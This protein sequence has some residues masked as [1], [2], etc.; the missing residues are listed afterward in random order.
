MRVLRAA[1][2]MLTVAAIA[3]PAAG[4]ATLTVN[5]TF[6]ETNA[7]DGSCSLRE[8][9]LAVD[10]PGSASGDCA[11]AAFGA[12]T[13]VL[14]PGRY[15]LGSASAPHVSLQIA[16]TVTNLTIEGAGVKQTTIDAFGLGNRVF[17]VSPGASVTI[18]D[19]EVAGGQAPDGSAGSPGGVGGDGQNGGAILNQ[20]VLSLVDAM[21]DSSQAGNGGAGGGAGGA[22]S[23]PAS[24]GGA[25]GAGGEGG[26]IFNTGALTLTGATIARTSSGAGGSGGIGG[27]ESTTNPGG[28]GGAGGAGGNGA[29]LANEGG[30]VTITASTIRGNTGG[31]AGTGGTGGGSNNGGGS[32]GGTG[33]IGGAGSSG[34]GVWS[35]GGSLHIT[36]STIASN[37]TGDGGGGGIGG[38]GVDGGTGGHGAGGGNSGSGGG[39][40]VSGL[41]S[42]Q[43]VNVTVVGNKVGQPGPAGAGGAGGTTGAAGSAGTA[44]AGGGLAGVSAAVLAVENSLLALNG[45]SNCAPST[46]TDGGHNLSFGDAT[47]PPSFANGDPNLGPLQ[48]NGG[49]SWTVSLLTGSAAIDQIPAS[50]ADCPATDQRGVARPVGPKCDIGA[51]EAAGPRATTNAATAVGRTNATLNG[52]VTPNSGLASVHF[53]YGTT[54][55]Y[56]S[57]TSARLVTGV[58]PTA[59][60]ATVRG[61][62]AGVTYHFRLVATTSDGTVQGVDRTFTTTI[63]PKLTRPTLKAKRFKAGRGTTIS[64]SDS[65][66]ATT[67]FVVLRLIRHR[68][69]SRVARFSHRDKAGRNSVQYKAR[70]LKPGSYRLQSTPGLHGLKGSTVSVTFTI[71]R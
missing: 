58:T 19:L 13:I 5:S 53:I 6:D 68:K 64:Y 63:A 17:G 55:K 70:G 48:D 18:R 44:G 15:F 30:T 2:A 7:S 9:I 45:G 21:I 47:C 25:G 24:P 69:P 66:A 49:P 31:A 61:L 57:S 50:G 51:Y 59:V 39:V 41:P 46:V 33:G 65:K 56:G 37:T 3:A 1:S 43:L 38:I 29:G 16:S 11:A 14:K 60:T 8:A 67:N 52:S 22:P 71:T 23:D 26:G 32:T 20:G 36:N 34:G 54:T 4:A 35:T 10:S 62:R 12:N 40:A 42:P 28:S 27:Q